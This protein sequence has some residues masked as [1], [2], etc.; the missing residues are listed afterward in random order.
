MVKL[1]EGR[2][3]HVFPI[4]HCLCSSRD[5][6]KVSRPISRQSGE[7]QVVSRRK[8][9]PSTEQKPRSS[10]KDFSNLSCFILHSSE[11]DKKDVD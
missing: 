5:S 11:K 1:L 10:V 3:C 8:Y 9:N 7:M 6:T 4:A 2:V